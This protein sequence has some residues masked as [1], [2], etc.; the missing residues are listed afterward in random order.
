MAWWARCCAGMSHGGRPVKPPAL[1]MHGSGSE[2]CLPSEVERLLLDVVADGFVL[3]CCGPRAAP[4]ALVA[5]YRWD[6]YV[7]LV[8]IRRFDRVTTARVSTPQHGNLDVFAPAVVVWVYEGP[9]QWALGA[10]M[11]LV[12]PQHPNAPVSAHPAPP[13]LYIPRAEQRPMTIRFP[14]PSRA[15]IRAAR[16][17]AAMTAGGGNLITADPGHQAN[18]PVEEC[19]R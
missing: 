17:A 13:S 14:P 4:L 11:N 5:S 7:D 18:T 12:H 10:L 6:G 15:G 1:S 8:T 19:V 2:A 9:P 16:L 3:Y